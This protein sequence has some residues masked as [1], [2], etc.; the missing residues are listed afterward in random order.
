MCPGKSTFTEG[1]VSRAPPP[2]PFEAAAT[3]CPVSLST[4]LTAWTPQHRGKFSLLSRVRK[5]I[6]AIQNHFAIIQRFKVPE[7]HRV[8]SPKSKSESIIFWKQSSPD[9]DSKSKVKV[10]ESFHSSQGICLS[11]CFSVYFR[12]HYCAQE[13]WTYLAQFRNY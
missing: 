9:T 10:G 7:G 13:G 11:R 8:S 5:A 3:I 1:R 6:V 2:S 4:N 12:L